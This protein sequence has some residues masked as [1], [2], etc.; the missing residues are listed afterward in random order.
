MAA[1][2][3]LNP[4]V[5]L[6][7]SQDVHE[8]LQDANDWAQNWSESWRDRIKKRHSRF[9]NFFNWQLAKN[10]LLSFYGQLNP[11]YL[12]YDDGFE[13]ITSV[14]DNANSPGR[15]GLRL[16]SD[17]NNGIGIFANIET[18]LRR[19]DYDSLFG[20]GP[21]EETTDWNRT[22]LR[23]AEVRLSVPGVG[24]FSLG[25]GNMA[26]DGITGFDFSNTTVTATNSVGD[27]ASGE[28]AVFSDGMTSSQ[29]LETFFPTFE[30]SRRFRVRYDSQAENGLSWSV[31][32]G[33][34]VLQD[35]NDNTYADAALRYETKWRQFRVKTGIGYAFNDKSPDFLS[36]SLAM[37][38]DHTGLNLTFAAGTN[39]DD[40]SYAYGKLGLIQNFIKWGG[41][42]LSID[43]Y[44]SSNPASGASGSNSQGIALVQ[45]IN[46]NQAQIYATYRTYQI[47]GTVRQYQ[48][49]QVLAGGIRFT[50]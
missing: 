9:E 11:M 30:A 32:L 47:D 22:L 1:A 43:F 21:P 5:V 23:K 37:I 15:L 35:N 46:A 39:S 20:I 17:L 29:G 4:F 34:E 27:T 6:A 3:S 7:Q 40:G 38:D 8:V 16:E 45:D 25:Q 33:T 44:T 2:L 13:T 42:A 12:N 10:T 50:W 49:V 26:A 36:G 14:R 31:S 28:L 18:G 24:F 41:T 19:T 48:D